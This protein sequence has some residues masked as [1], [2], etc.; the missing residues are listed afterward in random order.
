M[1]DST[2]QDNGSTNRDAD[3]QNLIK[4]QQLNKPRK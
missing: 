4:T 3:L 1:P 2:D